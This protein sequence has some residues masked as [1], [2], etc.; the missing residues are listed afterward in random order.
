MINVDLM[1][2]TEQFQASKFGAGP[3]DK[4]MSVVGPERVKHGNW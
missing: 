1:R 3:A 4:H 2:I